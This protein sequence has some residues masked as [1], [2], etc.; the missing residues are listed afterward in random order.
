MATILFDEMI[1]INDY[2][3]SFVLE[4]AVHMKVCYSTGT[5]SD[6]ALSLVAP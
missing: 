6:V 5:H 4:K 3:A 1:I 2:H